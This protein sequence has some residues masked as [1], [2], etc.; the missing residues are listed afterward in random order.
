MAK[1]QKAIYIKVSEEQHQKYKE[2]VVKNKTDI[3]TL[4]RNLLDKAVQEGDI[5]GLGRTTKEN[6]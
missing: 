4:V 1:K 6:S 5:N 2:F 3:S